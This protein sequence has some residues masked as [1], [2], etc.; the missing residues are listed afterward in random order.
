LADADTLLVTASEGWLLGLGEDSPFNVLYVTRDGAHSWQQ[1]SVPAPK[2]VFPA[3][4]TDYHLPTFSDNLHGNLLVSYAHGVND[5]VS[6]VLFAT[7]DGGQTWKT[8]RMVTNFE[9]VGS[10]SSTVTDS[11]WII[12]SGGSRHPRLT[13]VGAGARIDASNHAASV[14]EGR[15]ENAP[16]SFVSPTEGWI[17]VGDGE[18]IST[19]DGGA[20]WTALTPGPQPHVIQP[21]G[22]FIPRQ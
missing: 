11:T 7:D 16:L 3:T 22:S 15:R 10:I 5:S 6:E 12:P 2:E 20:T 4:E 9:D 21:H 8:D 18:L 1:V 17:V 13:E 19:T 14:F